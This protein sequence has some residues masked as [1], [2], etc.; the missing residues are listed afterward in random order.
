MAE[1][2]CCKEEDQGGVSLGDGMDVDGAVQGQNLEKWLREVVRR[3]A[4]HEQR[5]KSAT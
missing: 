1:D 3:K 5:W 4:G 2:V